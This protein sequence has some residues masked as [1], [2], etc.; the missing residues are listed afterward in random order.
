MEN[1]TL[2]RDDSTMS[3]VGMKL[4]E[5]KSGK[6]IAEIKIENYDFR[7]AVISLIILIPVFLYPG[8]FVL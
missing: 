7:V 1:Y 2:I 5:E 8:E 3:Q 4:R 6:V